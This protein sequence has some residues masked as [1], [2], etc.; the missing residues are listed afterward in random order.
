MNILHDDIFGELSYDY[1][2]SRI[3]KIDFFGDERQVELFFPCDEGESIELSQRRAYI[4]FNEFK[5]HY[6]SLAEEAI[7]NYYRGSVDEFRDRF[8]PEFADEMAPLIDG[9]LGMKEIV[10]PTQIIIQQTF[11]SEDRVV[12]IIY[13]CSWDP[14]FGLAVKFKNEVICEVGHQNIVL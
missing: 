1:G 4:K 13:D 11:G 10:K 9:K 12:G 14:Q 5:D 2:W 7:F 3:Y 6:M 8:G